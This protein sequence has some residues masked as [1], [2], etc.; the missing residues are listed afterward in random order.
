MTVDQA[1]RLLNYQLTPQKVLPGPSRAKTTPEK[2]ADTFMERVGRVTRMEGVPISTDQG[3]IIR[4][5][6]MQAATDLTNRK[7]PQQETT[8]KVPRTP[9]SKKGGQKK[10]G[11][12]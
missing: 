10:K 5:I 8:P 1:A 12:K 9:K 7:A 3:L 2:D 4:A 6:F 11:K